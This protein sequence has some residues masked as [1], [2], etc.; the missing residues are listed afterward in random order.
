MATQKRR[1]TI[2]VDLDGTILSYGHWLG[3]DHYGELRT[4]AIRFLNK[5]SQHGDVVIHTCRANFTEEPKLRYELM[6]IFEAACRPQFAHGHSPP[7][8]R[9]MKDLYDY[10]P[11]L[12]VWADKGKPLAA[13]YI[14]D[15]A[16]NIPANPTPE[17]YERCYEWAVKFLRERGDIE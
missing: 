3:P 7:P 11:R 17:E 13:I 16:G 12:T 2:A 5:L 6:N 4:G 15:R 9:E 14:D 1:P 8:I 10:P